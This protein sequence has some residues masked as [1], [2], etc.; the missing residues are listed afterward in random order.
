M[1]EGGRSENAACSHEGSYDGVMAL[2]LRLAF[3]FASES[4]CRGLPLRRGTTAQPMIA[5]LMRS[6]SARLRPAPCASSTLGPTP[7]R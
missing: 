2:N 7:L 3:F 1:T 4:E 5:V 6:S